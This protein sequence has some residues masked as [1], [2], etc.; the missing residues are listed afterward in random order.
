MQLITKGRLNELLSQTRM[1]H[2]QQT[3][4]L[5]GHNLLDNDALNDIGAHLKKQQ[6]GLLYDL[7]L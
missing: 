6:E 4:S 1:H 2:Y 5:N 7:L 3:T